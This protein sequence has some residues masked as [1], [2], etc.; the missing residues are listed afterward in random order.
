MNAQRAVAPALFILEVVLFA[1]IGCVDRPSRDA[2]TAEASSGSSGDS[3]SSVAS[4]SGPKVITAKAKPAPKSDPALDG[5][6]R[7]AYVKALEE[8]R[9]LHRKKDFKGAIKGFQRALDIIPDDARALSELGWSAFNAKDLGLAEGSLGKAIARTT[10]PQLRGSTLYNLGRVHE[11]EGDKRRAVVD[12]TESLRARL[13]AVVLA[14]LATLDVAAAQAFDL[15]APKSAL[16]PFGDLSAACSAVT[17]TLVERQPG[18]KVTCDPEAA[19]GSFFVGAVEAADVTTPWL[20]ARVIT[21]CTDSMSSCATGTVHLAMQTKADGKWYVA[22]DVESAYNP[23]AFGIYESVAG[24]KIEV[25]DRVVGGFPEVVLQLRHDRSDSDLGWNEV[26][27]YITESMLLCGLGPSGVP[28]CTRP[29]PLAHHGQR[30]VLSQEDDAP[31]AKHPTLFDDRWDVRVSFL[32]GGPVDL[33]EGGGKIPP[34][35]KPI[36]GMHTL[37]WP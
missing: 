16:G 23:G 11:D 15:L 27:S 32:D 6:K 12:Y 33:A 22:T 2:P 20:A 21:T 18:A 17:K 4:A 13:S 31:G 30:V 7:K 28:S 29:I 36:R 35:V 24:E 5:T 1:T 9:A 19:S 14:R 37:V 3:A 25:K 8:A 34:D 10:D 26:E